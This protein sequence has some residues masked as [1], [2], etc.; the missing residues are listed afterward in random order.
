MLPQYKIHALR[1]EKEFEGADLAKK[2]HKEIVMR[3]PEMS[4]GSIQ[5][6]GSERFYVRSVSDMCKMYLVDL[7]KDSSSDL[8]KQYLIDHSKDSCNCPDWPRVW[9][10]KHIT[11]VAHFSSGDSIELTRTTRIPVPQ[12]QEN[13]QDAQSD[14][15]LASDASAVPILKNMISISREFLSDGLPSSPGTIRSLRQVES[16]LSAV[17]QNSHTSQSALPDKENLPPNQRTWTETAERMGA[18]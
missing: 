8:S 4:A 13:S 18:K 16:H 7:G 17:I 5:S 3:A 12:I 15:G 6:L 9:L 2:R 14:A 1:Q 10:C 11:A